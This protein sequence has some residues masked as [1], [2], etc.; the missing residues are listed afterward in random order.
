M[1][2]VTASVMWLWL[3][4]LRQ[5]LYHAEHATHCR[6]RLDRP[7]LAATQPNLTS[8]HLTSHLS[9]LTR[10][11]FDHASCRVSFFAGLGQELLT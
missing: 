8:P 4:H 9:S 2:L 1:W 11:R 3:I 10:A 6:T 5:I 7:Q